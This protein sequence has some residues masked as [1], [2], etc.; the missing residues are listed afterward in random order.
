M[1]MVTR[2]PTGHELVDAVVDDLVDQVMQPSLIGAA[3]VHAGP[4]P[5]GLHTLQHLDVT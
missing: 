1:W 5:N 2:S 4:L 3:D